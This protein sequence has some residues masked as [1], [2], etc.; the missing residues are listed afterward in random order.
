LKD[1]LSKAERNEIAKKIIKLE[2][3]FEKQGD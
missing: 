3:G 2:Q 1:N